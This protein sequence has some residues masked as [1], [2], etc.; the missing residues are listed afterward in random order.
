MTSRRMLLLAGVAAAA[1]P[2]AASAATKPVGVGV[3]VIKPVRRFEMRLA[4]ANTHIA[5]RRPAGYR[6][7]VYTLA[8]AGGQFA[9]WRGGGTLVD[10]G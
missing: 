6:A 9:F 10:R 2:T 5:A 8:V 7:G 3:V 4:H 1:F